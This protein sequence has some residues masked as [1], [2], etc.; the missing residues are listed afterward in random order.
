MS[1][2]IMYI[3]SLI[4]AILDSAPI[5]PSINHDGPVDYNYLVSVFLICTTI[6]FTL[7]KIFGLRS[8]DDALRKS[9]YM[10][11]LRKSIGAE[12]AAVSVK[13]T[14]QAATL[15]EIS[16]TLTELNTLSAT[17]KVIVESLQAGLSDVKTD[18]R[19]LVQRLD[20][21]LRQMMDIVS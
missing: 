21:L 8:N 15:K 13:I 17:R 4:V 14:E 3:A 9:K 2:N 5:I 18:N 10:E 12:I 11:E 20:D 1:K 19:E 16:A 7:I 6:A